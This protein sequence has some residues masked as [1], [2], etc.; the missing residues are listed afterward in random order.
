[1]SRGAA[2]MLGKWGERFVC[3]YLR[4]RNWRIKAVNYRCRLGELDIIAEKGI[5]I[6]FVE[7]K[8]RKGDRFGLPREAVT[9]EKQ[10]KLRATAELY[11]Q[12]H[13]SLRQPRFDVAEVYA[14]NGANKADAKITYIENAF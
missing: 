1:M 8:L 9:Y 5:Y 14:P 7:V 10:R 4:D 13:P 12:E 11:L 2:H 6:A 3:D